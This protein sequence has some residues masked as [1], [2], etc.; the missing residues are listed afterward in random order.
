MERIESE[1]PFCSG[2]EGYFIRNNRD[3]DGPGVLANMFGL[4]ETVACFA[5][6]SSI[7]HEQNNDNIVH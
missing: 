7:F 2:K 1:T 6:L 5:L 4:I 3:V